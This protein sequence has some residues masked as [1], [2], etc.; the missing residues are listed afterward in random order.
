MDG[1]WNGSNS[2]DDPDD[3]YS[4]CGFGFLKALGIEDYGIR[5]NNDF[6]PFE[7]DGAVTVD[8][9]NI[10]PALGDLFVKILRKS[11]Q[12]ALRKAL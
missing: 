4:R 9:R 12:A 11:K 5:I 1:C 8:S 6:N 7:Y 2:H 10:A 3:T